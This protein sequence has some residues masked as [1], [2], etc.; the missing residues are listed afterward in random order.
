M[1]NISIADKVVAELYKMNPKGL[2]EYGAWFKY[3]FDGASPSQI[4]YMSKEEQLR[5]YAAAKD[6]ASKREFRK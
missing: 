1:D 3:Y 2:D 6:I 4:M 5:C